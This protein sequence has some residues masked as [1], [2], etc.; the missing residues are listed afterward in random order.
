[1]TSPLFN[2]D[3]VRKAITL[4]VEPGNVFEIRALDARLN[5]NKWK[6][7]IVSGYFDNADAAVCALTNIDQAK[8][9][10][11]T[12]NPFPPDLLAR[13]C[14]RLDYVGKEPTTHD[15]DI[16]HRRWL[17]VDC[18]PERPA[19]ISATDDELKAALARVNEVQAFLTSMGWPDPIRAGSGNGGHLLYSINSPSEDG[20]IIKNVLTALSQKF[21]DDK[22][23]IDESVYNPSRI[24][25][26]Y[27]TLASKGDNVPTRPW[28]YSKIVTVP[29]PLVVVSTE[30]LDKVAGLLTPATTI[31]TT[32]TAV[33]KQIKADDAGRNGS[34]GVLGFLAKHGV[35][36][37]SEKHREGTTILTLTQCPF[38]S[39]HGGQNEVAVFVNSSG[40]WGFKCHHDS[41]AGKGWREFREHYEPGCYDHKTNT[42]QPISVEV[43]TNIEELRAAIV[44]I[45]STRL[46]ATEKHEAVAN[47]V[48]E[49]LKAKGS[50]YFHELYRDFSTAMFFDTES[51]K[52]LR[53]QSDEFHSMVSQLTGINMGN[54]C[55]KYVEAAVEVVALHAKGIRPEKFW[56]SRPDAIYLSNGDG[57]M[58]KITANSVTI[59]DN[60]T[61]AVLFPIGAT[62]PPWELVEPADPFESCQLFRGANVAGD[63]G[64]T[65][66]KTWLLSIPTNPTC[67]PP[68]VFTGQTGS[69]KTRLARGTA[70]L[71]G[72][73]F[74]STKPKSGEK[75][76]NDFWVSLD[77]GGLFTLDNADTR[78]DWLADAVASASTGAGDNRRQLYTD[79]GTQE[80]RPNAWLALTT[81]NPTFAQDVALADRL[82]VVRMNRRTGETDDEALSVEIAQN[83]NAGLSWIAETLAKALA[84]KQSTP[85]GLNK[86]HPDYAAFAVRLGRA[87]NEEAAVVMALS[88]AEEDKSRFNLENDP[89]GSAI[90]KLMASEPFT[91]TSAELLEKLAWVEPDEFGDT[92]RGARG[93]RLWSAKRLGKRLTTIW[94]HIEALYDAKRD[95]DGSGHAAVLSIR[96]KGCGIAVSSPEMGKVP[97]ENI[98]ENFSSSSPPNRNT[99]NDSPPLWSD[100]AI[101]EPAATTPD[102]LLAPQP[103]VAPYP[104]PDLRFSPQ[105]VSVLADQSV[106]TEAY[107]GLF[108]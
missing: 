80:F 44:G 107:K 73:P 26:L 54:P 67:K 81:L 85:K 83:R 47:V 60:G 88:A 45:L 55:F 100:L 90:I 93:N 25:K 99:A 36:I 66:V 57:R 10:Y 79:K 95:T 6:A 4:L 37:K 23:K 21:T 16:L 103:S 15:K 7:G 58:A 102:L 78:I 28:R 24:T 51:K 27:G 71:Y 41:C 19:G 31:S 2:A 76:E 105:S 74:M 68:L 77:A 108:D 50:F 30:L 35:Q 8:S 62:L 40:Q 106:P 82:L 13:R 89:V 42:R 97:R 29:E 17:L 39:G 32:S 87:M 3:D 63:H 104:E 34:S 33:S 49:F 12:M 101:V 91:G 72:V 56:T 22:V 64:K 86:R 1:M 69:G 18:D 46:P 70:E 11:I 61:D 9:I 5:V 38:D 65:L 84:D 43:P 59:E 53:I 98:A 96:P 48:V 20:G 14:N 75:S 94:V 92:A 52:L